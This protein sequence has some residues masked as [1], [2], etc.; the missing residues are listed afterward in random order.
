MIASVILFSLSWKCGCISTLMD[1]LLMELDS[2]WRMASCSFL[3]LLASP[4]SMTAMVSQPAFRAASKRVASSNPTVSVLAFEYPVAM[5]E[6]PGP[7]VGW[8]TT[9]VV[10]IMMLEV[11]GI[12][13]CVIVGTFPPSIVC[14][15][16]ERY[17]A[18]VPSMMIRMIDDGG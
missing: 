12:S 14:A 3:K 7:V 9:A 5:T 6:C 8:G 16:P 15:V 4:F 2:A 1:G 18:P 13:V 11:G 10:L 17:G